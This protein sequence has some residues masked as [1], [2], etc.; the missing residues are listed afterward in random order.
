MDV[1]R[2]LGVTIL[3]I[4]LIIAAA[5]IIIGGTILVNTA[6]QPHYLQLAQ[7]Q[8]LFVW[9]SIIGMDDLTL[10]SVS[11]N[12]SE[13][14]TGIFL[15]YGVFVL[16]LIYSGLCVPAGIGLFYMKN[17]G[18]YLAFAV[19]IFS[20]IAGIIAIFTMFS[21]ILLAFGIGLIVYLMSGVKYEFE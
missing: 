17:W 15:W 19:G 8:G 21:L 4:L 1:H 10:A 11:I 13:Q 3:S 7:S 5:L 9:F 2:P 20:I 16:F 18:R 12:M 6:L 14:Q